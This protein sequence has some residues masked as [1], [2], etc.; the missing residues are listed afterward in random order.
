MLSRARDERIDGRFFLDKLKKAAEARA[1]LFKAPDTTAFRL[2]NGEGDGI[3]AD[4]VALTVEKPERRRI[5]RLKQMGSCFSRFF[6]LV[7]KETSVDPFISRAGQHPA[8]S[9]ILQTFL[10]GQAEKSG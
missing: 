10:S 1:H 4:A 8:D 9:F 5:G 7:Q 2:F 6:Q 3:G